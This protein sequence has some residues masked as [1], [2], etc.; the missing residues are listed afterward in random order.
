MRL[1]LLPC[2]VLPLSLFAGCEAFEPSSASSP[3]VTFEDYEDYIAAEVLVKYH[4]AASVPEQED[5]EATFGLEAVE[6]V[7]ANRT[8]RLFVPEDLKVRD[9]VEALRADPRVEYAEPNYRGH[10]MGSVNDPYTSLQWN[11]DLINARTAWDVT[12]GAG[13][14]VAVLDT[15]VSKSGEDRPANF[16]SGYDYIDYDSDPTDRNGHGTH[17]AGTIAQATN[18]GK[19]VAGVAHGVSIMPVRVLDSSGAGSVS[20][21]SNGIVW[22]ADQGAD[23]LNMSLGT[24][25]GSS[26]IKSAVDYARSRGVVIVAAAGNEYTNQINYPAAYDGVIAVG[27]VRYDRT[28]ASYSNTGTGL[29]FVAPGGDVNV[30]QN[31]DGYADGI[32]Q[33]TFE[34]SSWSYYFYDGTSMATPHVAAAAA[35]L[36][37]RGYSGYDAVYAQLKAT[38]TDLGSAGYDTAYGYGLINVG[39]AVGSGSDPDE[40][41]PPATVDADLDGYPS[42]SDCDD[43]RA[44]VNPGASESCGNARDDDCDGGV[45]EGCTTSDT[46]APTISGVTGSASGT[47]VTLNWITNEPA[48][49]WVDFDCCGPYGNDDL[50]TNH[51]MT[52]TVS[53]GYTY[54]FQFRSA[55]AAGNSTTTGSYY[56]AL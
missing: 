23:V 7:G 45:D 13:A 33:E 29:D 10:A 19:G 22:A 34:G 44:S 40:D 31:G 39:L 41:D 54:Y 28:R 9:V 30:D 25:S 36:V 37:A 51:V 4:D 52:F 56:I 17:V 8:L 49:T 38:A 26:T 6:E 12:S 5:I 32:L 46:T 43:S 2:S 3:S 11:L 20:A 24:Y 50:V 21:I 14:V 55:D 1:R 16:V 35:L 47:T 27:A 42:T 15:G 48:T 18:N 53:R